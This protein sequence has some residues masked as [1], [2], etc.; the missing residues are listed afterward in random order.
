ME[1]QVVHQ[2]PKYFFLKVF[3]S[4]D[5]AGS[6]PLLGGK[7]GA[8]D[9]QDRIETSRQ[10]DRRLLLEIEEETGQRRVAFGESPKRNGFSVAVC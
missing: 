10:R 7:I 9:L 4:G 5:L 8:Y 2:R 1:I 6:Y 3:T